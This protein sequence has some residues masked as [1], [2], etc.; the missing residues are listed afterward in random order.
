MRAARYILAA[1]AV[2]LLF[3]ALMAILAFTPLGPWLSLKD[4]ERQVKRNIGPTE[5]QEWA[6]NLLARYPGDNVYY[7]D[8]HGTN[9]PLGLKSVKGYYHWVRIGS[10]DD[11][12]PRVVIFGGTRAEPY[13][14]VGSPS[15]VITNSAAI[16]WKPGIY[17]VKPSG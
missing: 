6:T 5:L 7:L 14:L 3:I 11:L 9:L 17:F 15:F 4:L 2:F 13:L 1:G 10:G 12:E 8:Y 16:L